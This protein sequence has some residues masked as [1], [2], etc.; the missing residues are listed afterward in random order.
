MAVGAD[1]GL[2]QA[3][4]GAHV[5]VVFT[6]KEEVA[7]PSGAGWE[8]PIGATVVAVVYVQE[9]FAAGAKEPGR[10][11]ERALPL[12]RSGDVAENVP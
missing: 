1:A 11:G 12:L 4:L 5:S 9:E 10:G 3:P 7:N 8:N 6:R 2:V